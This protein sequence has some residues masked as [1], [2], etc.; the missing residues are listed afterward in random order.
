MLPIELLRTTGTNALSFTALGEFLFLILP[1]LLRLPA[2][3]QKQP[4]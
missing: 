1:M 4:E 3:V 2:G